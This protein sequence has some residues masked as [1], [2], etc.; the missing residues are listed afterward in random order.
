MTITQDLR[1][2]GGTINS[3]DLNYNFDRIIEDLQLAVEGVVFK[4]G[5]TVAETIKER[6]SYPKE[7]LVQGLWVAVSET[8]IIYEYNK[9][10]DVRISDTIRY[11]GINEGD[12]PDIPYRIDGDPS[13]GIL[14]NACYVCNADSKDS[15]WSY[16]SVTTGL[17]YND[18]D[19]AVYKKEDFSETGYWIRV[20][21]WIP[22]INATSI[23]ENSL[24][25]P[26]EDLKTENKTNLVSAINEIHDDLGTLDELTTTEKGSAV[27]AI[28][29]L[30]NR[31]GELAD[32]KTTNKTNI[33]SSIN[34]VDD[35]VGPIETLTTLNKGNLTVAINE[36]DLGQGDLTGLNTTIK[37]NL[38]NAINEVQNELGDINILS[39]QE[40][41]NAVEAI[42]ELDA[43]IG[44]LNFLSTSSKDSV[45]SSINEVDSNIGPIEDLTTLNKTNTVSAINEL[46][47]ITDALRG[48]T[49]IIGRIELD[50]QDITQ[51]LLTQRALEIM[52]GTTVQ[53]GWTLID[54]E[55]H[56]WHYNGEN[57]QDL[58]QPNIYPAQN[59]ILGTVRGNASGDISILDGNM[60]VLH[61]QNS[62]QLDGHNGSYYATKS[63]AD[64]KAD[65]INVLELDNTTPY[66]PTENYHPATKTYVDTLS[67][68]AMWGNI[69]NNIEDQEDLMLLINDRPTKS[70]VLTLDNAIPYT[71]TENYHPATKTYVDNVFLE[72]NMWGKVSGDIKDQQDLQNEL[73]NKQNKDTAWNTDNLIVDTLEPAVP[74]QGYIIWI[75][76]NS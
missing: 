8:G 13:S 66:T 14:L 12:L 1:K 5:Y 76:L 41:N 16:T 75:D 38:V 31:I 19:W 37:D 30:D 32:L 3:T 27:I 73:V 74:A 64:T 47:N 70:N 25:G 29:E 44:D 9:K 2:I 22:I 57:W 11:F 20:P 46:K 68:G 63:Y 59:D 43:D 54:N 24:T 10:N 18:G 53:A 62:S 26:L 23:L 33:V 56:E 55:Q 34:E 67:S 48:A 21:K 39:T 69:V 6:N 51:E 42:N 7:V 49:I 60:T 72:N 65:K 50:T 45:V 52:G 15:N 40:K 28:N 71:P 36:L 4:D 17:N 35:N 61:S 58:E